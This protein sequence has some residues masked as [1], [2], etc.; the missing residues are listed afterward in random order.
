MPFLP[1]N[2]QRQST[3]GIQYSVMREKKEN[4]SLRL[5]QAAEWRVGR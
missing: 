1:T 2:Q 3:E 5:R 4:V